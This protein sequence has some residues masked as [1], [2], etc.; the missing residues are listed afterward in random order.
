MIDHLIDKQDTFEI[1]RNQIAAILVTE[2]AN[3]N[4]ACYNCWQGS[5]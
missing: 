2:T 5:R 3:Q 4:G 1:V